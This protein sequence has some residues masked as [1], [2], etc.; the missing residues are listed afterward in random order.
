M[1]P[2]RTNPFTKRREPFQYLLWLGILSSVFI[3]TV[4][5]AVYIMRKSGP[6]WQEVRLPKLFIFSTFAISFSSVTLH[7]A[8]RSFR[9]DRFVQYRVYMGTTLTL[10][11]LFVILQLL[12]WKQLIQAGITTA[13][14][15]SVG[16]VY[17][18]SGLHIL[19][20]LGGVAALG[21]AFVE[22]LKH[23][24]YVDSFV[25][26]VNPPN[27]LKIKLIT[28]YWHFVDVLWLYL[29]GFLLYHHGI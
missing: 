23:F 2:K 24:S 18:I 3:F 22:S 10:G 12:G 13:N 6:Q 28:L 15:P 8:N 17:I 5:L 16:F 7:I 4:L 9:S 20:I 11:V 21:W 26:S 27:Q 19:H 1:N 14:N 29:F 25:Y